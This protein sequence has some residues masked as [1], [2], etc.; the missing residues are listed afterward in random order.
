MQWV[1]TT[2]FLDDLK[3][4][5]NS[6]AWKTFT[7]HFYPVI[8]AF[9]KN[10]GLSSADAEDAT[11]E[12]IIQFLRLYR[13]NR[14]Q[15]EKGHL[16]HW[17][18]GVARNV[19]R[20]FI[21]KRPKEYSVPDSCTRTSFWGSVPDEKAI[22]HTWMTE[23]QRVILSRCLSRVRCEVDEKTYRAFNMYALEQ[24]PVKAVCEELDMTPN[25]VYIAK[26]RVLTKMRELKRCYDE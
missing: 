20:D 8:L 24:Q 7:D 4:S 23:W 9:A 3:F 16:S 2:Q 10:M 13:D 21:K 19:I 5:D 1:T 15:R 11:Q 6:V 18:F 17:I 12:T 14:F 26:N 22:L 25:A